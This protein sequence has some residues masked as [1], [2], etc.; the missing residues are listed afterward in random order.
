M[1]ENAKEAQGLLSIGSEHKL[2][3]ENLPFD[4]DVWYPSLESVTFSTE[5]FPLTRTEAQSVLAYQ[6]TRY[7][8]KKRL[9]TR[10]VRNLNALEERLD[11]E[12][13]R[14]FPEGAFMRLC[15]RSPKDGDPYDRQS[16]RDSYDREL[17][18]LVD[19][20]EELNANTK[21][22]AVAR[23]SWLGV[24]NGKDAMS[25][26]LTSERVFADLHDWIR[27]GEPEQVVLRKFDPKLRMEYEFRAYINNNKITVLSQYD[28]YCVYPD[29][30]PLKEKIERAIREM[31]AKAHPLV[32]CSSYCMDFCYYPEEDRAIVIEISPFRTCTGSACFSW[33]D[34]K[35]QMHN[36]PFEFRLN[37]KN[38]QHLEQ[39]VEANW[40]D[41]WR[42]N[43]PSYESFYNQAIQDP[44]DPSYL[45]QLFTFVKDLIFGNQK[46]HLL[47]FYGTLKRGFHWNKKF[48]SHSKFVSEARSS[49]NLA[50]VVG[51][52][53]VPY[54]LG[55]VPESEGHRV[56]GELWL[57]DDITLQG[58]DEYEG[59][60][61]GYYVRVPIEV[62][63]PTG[64]G[65]AQVYK[66][67]NS[68]EELKKGPFL[69]EYSLPFHK[70]NYH[71]IQH[72]AV[73]QQM[74]M[75]DQIVSSTH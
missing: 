42:Q 20:G 26:L 60:S 52:S 25:L 62:E 28:H 2:R 46:E 40:E 63:T 4:I 27:W 33:K 32:G 72:I 44:N 43:P 54:L 57:V 16:L 45:S 24:S 10:D 15:G 48:L 71:A 50:L 9:T 64:H 47:F 8:G 18:K 1:T 35:E 55:D 31:W 58:L 5:F 21:L 74:Y 49:K 6:D 34:D 41:R 70:A 12:I 3:S 51:T 11:V 7:R 53:G 17:G 19:S 37:Q 59:I 30:P 67:T 36:G 22:R 13:K 73:K 23:V 69:S 38:H 56:I 66:K 65:T 75:N 29:L 61:K 68:S 14:H 39:L